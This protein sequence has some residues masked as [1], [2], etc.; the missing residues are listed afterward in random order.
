MSGKTLPLGK[1]IL[2]VTHMGSSDDFQVPARKHLLKLSPLPLFT[3]PTR[4]Y[5]ELLEL[6]DNLFF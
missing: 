1:A 4:I 6:T 3:H 2:K 5:I